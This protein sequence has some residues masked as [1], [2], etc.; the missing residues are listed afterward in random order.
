MKKWDQPKVNSLSLGATMSDIEVYGVGNGNGNGNGNEMICT[1]CCKTSNEHEQNT[2]H[3]HKGWCSS[4][5]TRN[6]IVPNTGS[7]V[8]PPHS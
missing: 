1:I 8:C 5:G 2:S 4:R 3:W 7:I 6:N